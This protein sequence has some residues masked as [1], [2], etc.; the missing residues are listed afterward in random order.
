[1]P[2]PKKYNT[3]EE[4]KAARN[5]AARAR[6]AAKKGRIVPVVTVKELT[7]FQKKYG[8]TPEMISR[9]SMPVV[10]PK[11][12]RTTVTYTSA[13]GKK[14]NTYSRGPG[15]N[16][17]TLYI[18]SDT[19]Y[20]NKYGFAAQKPGPKKGSKRAPKGT[21]AP[22][23]AKAPKGSREPNKYAIF[24]KNNFAAVKA[25]NPGAKPAE[26]MKIIGGMWK[27]R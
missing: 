2:R 6:Y 23:A 7:P 9:A 3:E 21:K 27:S 16:V 14:I 13:D 10:M 11:G 17:P 25:S 19:Q 20:Y 22:K 8:I 24:V 5:A 1:M 26:V 18:G 4:R 12:S 15:R